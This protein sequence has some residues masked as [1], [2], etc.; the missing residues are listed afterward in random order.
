[1]AIAHPGHLGDVLACMPMV[2]AL[3]Q[4]F[5]RLRVVF[6]GSRYTRPLLEAN[7]Q[8]DAVLDAFEFVRN[9]QVLAP[10]APEVLLNPWFKDDIGEAAQRLGVPV[11]I[12]NLRRR[13]S[14]RWCNRFVWQGHRHSG[15]HAAQL[16]LA[17]LRALGIRGSLRR[18]ELH[19]YIDLSRRPPLDPAV[20][21]LLQPGRFH[22]VLHA[23]SNGNGREWPLPSFLELAQRLPP[24]RFQL[25]ITGRD[26]EGARMR[27][28]C[29]ALFDLAQVTDMTGRLSMEQLL[30]F[31]AEVDGLVGSG[32][33][34]LHLAAALGRRTLGLFPARRGIDAGR[35]AP[36]GARA[37]ALQ[38]RRSCLPMGANCPRRYEGGPCRCMNAITPDLVAARVTAWAC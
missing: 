28:E 26:T 1:M 37:E 30:P 23:K 20:A 16:N 5:P 4:A 21:S 31:L 36:L 6:L 7:P 13:Q 17:L 9:P 11:R 32:T 29:P 22:L 35:W 14:L 27:A 19:R 38:M 33:G 8:I 15:L 3:R 12:G 10:Y 34:P 2:G 24:Q 18:D 25:L